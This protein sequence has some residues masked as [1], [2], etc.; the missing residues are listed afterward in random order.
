MQCHD[1]LHGTL[2]TAQF[3]NYIATTYIEIYG[4]SELESETLGICWAKTVICGQFLNYN[5]EPCRL[6][7]HHM[8]SRGSWPLANLD[9]E[10]I[11]FP[12]P[13][14]SSWWRACIFASPIHLLTCS[15][16]PYYHW[17]CQNQWTVF[18]WS[19]KNGLLKHAKAI[20]TAVR[21]SKAAVTVTRQNLL[22]SFQF[23]STHNQY[24]FTSLQFVTDV[25]GARL[26]PERFDQS[27]QRRL[28][29]CPTR[30]S[31]YWYLYFCFDK[32][33][34]ALCSQALCWLC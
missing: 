6:K 28:V 13:S 20:L 1:A 29:S 21:H 16:K 2:D 5:I 11:S 14:E 30:L 8:V 4:P 24:Y 34:M 27:A 18:T 23:Q 32:Y 3:L 26:F 7:G 10:W 22:V 17:Q 12:I 31:L 25:T 15:R 19:G 9:G 33:S